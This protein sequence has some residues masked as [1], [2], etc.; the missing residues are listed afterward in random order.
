MDLAQRLGVSTYDPIYFIVG[1]N[2]GLNSK[3]QI[4]FKYSIFR[5]GSWISDCL[6]VPSHIYLSY[7][8][9]SL[10][11]LHERSSPFKDTSYKPRLFYARDDI[12]TSDSKHWQLGL[13][14]GFA[15]E[16]NGKA[17]PDSR[18]VNMGYVRP[19]L[20]YRWGSSQRVYVAPMVVSYVDKLEN[21]NI[22]DYRG[23]VDFLM[24]YGSGNDGEHNLNAWALLRKGDR[25]KYGSVEVNLAIPFRYLSGGR[26]NGWLL[27]QYFSGW[28]EGIMDYTRKDT[29]QFR[30]GFAILVQ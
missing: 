30:A 16:S 7:T 2:G 9:T 21:E 13:E 28:S 18:S 29:A 23:H 8:Q 5:E 27:T 12:W 15:H 10:W 26:M 3:F 20:S 25:K 19:S 17:D 11:D 6:P 24:G 14:G 4:S 22:A 1:N